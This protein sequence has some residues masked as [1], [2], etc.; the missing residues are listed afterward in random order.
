MSEEV[1]LLN[2]IQT[3]LESSDDRQTKAERIAEAIRHFR[4]YRWVGIYDVDEKEIVA[5]AWSGQGAPAFPRFPVSKGL[6]G[7]AVASRSTIISND[8]EN[9]S[10][11]LTAFGST[12][13]EIIVP[14]ISPR[15]GAVIGTIDVESERK[16]AFTETDSKLLEECARE[17]APLWE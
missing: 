6:S 2:Q 1:K 9:D 10:R 5:I 17:L 13:S 15:T 11:Y 12:Q 14:V 4:N 3:V 7:E 8:V 16:N